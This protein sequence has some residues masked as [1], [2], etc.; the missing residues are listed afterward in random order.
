MFNIDNIIQAP[1]LHHP[2]THQVIDP[3]F[4]KEDSLVI[5]NASKTLLEKYSNNWHV[6]EGALSVGE[7]Y[8]DI[9]QEA[10]N[11]IMDAN[12]KLLD[13]VRSMVHQ[14]PYYRKY[15]KIVSLP[16]F[17]L[18]PPNSGWMKVHDESH[19]KISS[20]VVYLQPDKST[21][22][23]LFKTNDR[24]SERKEIDWKPNT[25]MM[26]CGQKKVT[27]HD[28]RTLDAPRITLNYMLRKMDSITEEGNRYSLNFSNGLSQYVNK[29]IPQHVI[30]DLLGNNIKRIID[31]N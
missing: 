12:T 9:G 3:W 4:S 28:F 6:G 14:Y 22:T 11:I 26:F 23:T 27:W 20:I 13:N 24:N 5:I 21:G 15:D 19:D 17:H 30:D 2:W 10:Y 7:V 18:L 31:W 25:A 1:I 16:H 29:D 8:N